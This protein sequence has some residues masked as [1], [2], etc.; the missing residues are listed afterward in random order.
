MGDLGMATIKDI[1]ERAGVSRGT[2]DRVLN[3][4]GEVRRE[5]KARVLR[6]V[7]ELDYH[8]NK[9][10]IAL[11]AQKKPVKIGIV[12]YGKDKPFF[13]DVITGIQRKAE[14]VS[15]YGCKL[16]YRSL[17]YDVEQ[18]I[19]ALDELYK[20]N[21]SGLLISP[22][23]DPRVR[24]RINKFSRSGVPV[25]TVNSDDASSDR[26]AYVGVNARKSGRTAGQLM[27]MLLRGEPAKVGIIT[28]SH[29]VLGHEYRVVGFKEVVS[30]EFPNM[31]VVFEEESQ[32]DNHKGYMV[33]KE[34][35]K[36]HP[37]INAIFFTTGTYY[38]GCRAIREAAPTV[39]YTV[40]GFDELQETV[41]MMKQNVVN[42]TICQEPVLQGYRS[43]GILIDKVVLNRDPSTV[44]DYTDLVIKIRESL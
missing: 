20:E 36:S 17:P 5:T 19:A 27:G 23:N 12:L 18:Q 40:I 2:V 6:A 14:E 25:V 1:A 33:T 39:T 29:Q 15:I 35:L 31:E 16:I 34:M 43:L 26:I 7:E 24:E 9:A 21:I 11:A 37:E 4:R 32:D 13:D 30:E 28:G 8:P 44:L 22:Y 3:G 38:G 42:A 41:D 10:G